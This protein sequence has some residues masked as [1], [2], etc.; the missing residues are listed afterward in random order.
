MTIF[1]STLTV[2]DPIGLHARP[3]SEIVKA[4]KLT[5]F[6]VKLGRDAKSLVSVNSPLQLMALKGKTGEVLQVSVEA[7]D[8]AAA[9]QLI[10]SLQD[11][12]RG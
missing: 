3:A 12:L 5:G 1:K 2:T 7:E 9:L 4:V 11:L 10:D 6:S 8:E